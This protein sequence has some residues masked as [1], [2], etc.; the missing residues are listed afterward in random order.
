MKSWDF[1]EFYNIINSKLWSKKQID[2][3]CEYKETNIY[4]LKST[5]KYIILLLLILI[6]VLFVLTLHLVI[7]YLISDDSKLNQLLEN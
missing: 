6:F 7:K 1:N 4:E 5:L 3:Y 2:N